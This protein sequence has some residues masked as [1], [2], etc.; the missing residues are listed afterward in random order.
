M[1]I[2]S[3]HPLFP[4]F[5]QSTVDLIPASHAIQWP[6]PSFGALPEM[7]STLPRPYGW[8]CS[9]SSLFLV[10]PVGVFAI[11]G[12]RRFHSFVLVTIFFRLFGNCNIIVFFVFF[13]VLEK[14]DKF[15]KAVECVCTKY[16]IVKVF[17]Y[18]ITGCK[19]AAPEAEKVCVPI[20]A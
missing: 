10:T 12:D 17:M 4:H 6:H 8:P 5:Q 2:P 1:I 16:T 9:C 15:C 18:K 13:Y 20:E 11:C 3:P 7:P 14:I 19:P